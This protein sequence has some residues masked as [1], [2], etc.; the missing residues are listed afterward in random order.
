[1]TS[2]DEE[3]E[4]GELDGQSTRK[5]SLP[6]WQLLF[7]FLMWQWLYRVS[8]AAMN[9]LLRFLRT[10]VPPLWPGPFCSSHGKTLTVFT[11]ENP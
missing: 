5:V 8:N 1:M 7:F 4:A 6:V 9:T 11:E 3:E 2:S 10:F